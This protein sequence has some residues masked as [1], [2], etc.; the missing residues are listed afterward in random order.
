[1]VTSLTPNLGSIGHAYEAAR[2]DQARELLPSG[3][4]HA[5]EFL[6]HS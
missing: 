4:G 1:M 5:F 3:F 2:V 6:P